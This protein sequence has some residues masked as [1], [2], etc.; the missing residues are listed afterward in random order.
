MFDNRLALLSAL[1]KQFGYDGPDDL[2]AVKSWLK[3]NES[4]V[5]LDFKS[6]DLDKLW[7]KAVTL[8]VIGGALTVEEEQAAAADMPEEEEE[9]Q[10]M[11]ALSAMGRDAA[12]FAN[13]AASKTGKVHAAM[14]NGGQRKGTATWQERLY[15]KQINGGRAL[16]ETP[17][18]AAAVGAYVRAKAMGHHDYDRKAQDMEILE[19]YGAKTAI[20]SQNSDGGSLIQDVFQA[21]LIDIRETF[22][23]VTSLATNRAMNGPVEVHPR[24][25][26]DLT[27]Y[28][29]GEGQAITESKLGFD[30]VRLEAKK[31]ATLS[32][33]SSELLN[34]AAVS[35][36]DTISRNIAWSFEKDLE[37]AFVNGDGTSAYFGVMGLRAKLKGLS[38]TIANIA[39]LHVGTGNTYAELKLSDFEKTQALLPELESQSGEPV[40]LMHPR[41]FRG[42]VIPLLNTVNGATKTEVNGKTLAACIGA[43]VVFSNA[44]PRTEANSQ[45][46]AMYGWFD[47]AA[48]I[49]RVNGSMEIATS[50]EAYFAEDVWAIRGIHRAAITV[51]DVGNASATESEREPGPVVGLITAAS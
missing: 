28:T 13:A 11:R 36:A 24:Q 38:G 7:T 1:R 26:G 17:E 14:H 48:M 6:G 2:S 33:V 34:D 5:K 21:T 47:L 44:M 9:P 19:H 15:Q 29:P 4:V 50:T 45:V 30:T 31:R 35:I 42:V 8:N 22:G 39:G 40:W 23:G 18:E 25:T 51:H 43:P 3:E 27:V 49:G 46:C 12:R 37:N 20:S 32:K 10:E 41:F 16:Y